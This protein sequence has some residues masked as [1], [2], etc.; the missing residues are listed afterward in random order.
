[1]AEKSYVATSDGVVVYNADR[2]AAVT[3][4]KGGAVPPGSD[5][6]HVKM[7]LGRGLV[8]EGEAVGGVESDPDAAPPFTAPAKPTKQTEPSK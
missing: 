1:M 8:E 5:P 6:K 7:L 3:L 4:G 2:T